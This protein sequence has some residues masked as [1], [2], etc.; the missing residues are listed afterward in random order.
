M[1]KKSMLIALSITAVLIFVIIF[2]IS[3]IQNSSEN[4]EK[5]P[6]K[7]SQEQSISQNN[8]ELERIPSQAPQIVSDVIPAYP[9]R[10]DGGL[11]FDD[12]RIEQ[13]FAINPKNNQEIYVNIEYKGLYKSTDGGKTWNFSGKGIKALPRNDDPSR[14]CRELHFSLYIDPLNTQRLLLPGG[15]APG[16]VEQGLGGLV[17]ST[18][19]G[20]NWR[21]LFTSEMSAYTENVV[22]DPRNSD[23][24]YVT[25][26]AIPQGMSGPD[27]GKIFITKGIVYKTTDGGKTWE[28]LPTG[29]YENLRSTGIFLNSQNPAHL[30][31]A[32]FGL[33]PGSNVEKKATTEQWGFLETRDAGKT[34]SKRESTQGIGI[35]YIDV[36]PANINHFYMLASKDNIDKVYY[37][38]DGTLIE[39]N[40]PVN[41]AR[42]D[43]YDKTG[44]R[45][46]GFSLYAQPD[47][48]YESLDG[49]KTWVSV[50]KLPQGITN[51]DRA[52]HIL[53]DPVD[54]NTFYLSADKARVW[55]TLDKGKTWTPLLTLESLP[56]EF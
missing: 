36:S 43:P 20:K 28:E 49:G 4:E 9:I 48:I 3:N 45:L 39:G 50:G 2:S 5:Y 32:T 47:D 6:Q 42:Y 13:A 7:I 23:I 51:E 44:M 17:E 40:T 10:C 1:S 46:I 22:T 37:S 34:W 18:D 52:S 8:S 27:Q 30:I 21:Q 15:S 55:K 53:F 16:K 19:G 38:L 11:G 29:L 56:S 54:K 33:P 14:P 35:R 41:F 25:T 12:Y 31:V 26:A 24:I